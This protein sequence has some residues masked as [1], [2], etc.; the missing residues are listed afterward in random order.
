MI[1][2]ARDGQRGLAASPRVADVDRRHRRRRRPPCPHRATTT[3]GFLPAM[4]ALAMLLFLPLPQLLLSSSLLL[5]LLRMPFPLEAKAPTAIVVPHATAAYPAP[6]NQN[7]GRCWL[8]AHASMA[9][10]HIFA[11]T[12]M[13]PPLL[14]LSLSPSFSSLLSF[15]QS[16]SPPPPVTAAA[17]GVHVNLHDHP[18]QQPLARDRQCHCPPP[19]L[20]GHE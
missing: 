4:A 13:P 16:L 9:T 19:C 1:R 2:D 20:R 7:G 5:L 15:L 18:P 17:V 6:P 8:L 14:S 11:V 12:L 3:T 10:V